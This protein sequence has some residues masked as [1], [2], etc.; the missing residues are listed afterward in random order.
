MRSSMMV[1][2]L[3]LL[4]GGDLSAQ[5]GANGCATVVAPAFA[6]VSPRASRWEWRPCGSDC[7]RALYRDGRQVG[8]W[9]YDT[10]R[11]HELLSGDRWGHGETLPEGAPSPPDIAP[12]PALPPQAPKLPDYMTDGV[13]VAKIGPPRAAVNGHEV[14]VAE[15]LRVVGSKED[16]LPSDADKPFLIDVG[17]EEP[18]KRLTADLSSASELAA[19]RSVFRRQSYRP[20]AEMV[21]DRDGRVMYAPGLFCATATGKVVRLAE[22]YE[23]PVALVAALRKLPPDFDPARIPRAD[24]VKPQT[25][26][27]PASATDLWAWLSSPAVAPWACAG[28]LALVVFFALQKP[29]GS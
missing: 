16:K 17:P 18:G 6:Q 26:D 29:R 1:L 4:A 7:Q 20:E 19:Y 2:S 25:P 13:D 27:A 14:S 23:G 28:A 10:E 3:A 8:V 15:A 22:S 24:P 12:P 11:Y 9:R 21:R 5:W